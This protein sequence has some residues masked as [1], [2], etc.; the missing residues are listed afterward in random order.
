MRLHRGHFH[1]QD[2]LRLARQ[3]LDNVLL[4]PPQHERAKLL[5]QVFDLRLLIRVVQVEIVGKLD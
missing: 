1:T 3:L 4:Q 2:L 5:V